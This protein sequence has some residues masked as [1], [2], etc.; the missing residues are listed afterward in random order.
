MAN[1][2]KNTPGAPTHGRYTSGD[3][4]TDSANVFWKCV[5]SGAARPDNFVALDSRSLITG[6]GAGITAGTGTIYK[7]SVERVGGL[8]RTSILIDLTGLHSEAVDL[9]IIGVDAS[10]A[11]A[12]IG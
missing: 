3:I 11:V 4:I 10:T 2:T 6:A 9:D 7:S 12:H 1:Y 5:R 8:I